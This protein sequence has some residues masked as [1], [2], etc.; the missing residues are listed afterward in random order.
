MSALQKS[1]QCLSREINARERKKMY[2][3]DVQL[4]PPTT[5]PFYTLP[6]KILK[7]KV[8]TARSKVKSRSHHDIASIH[9]LTNVPTKY[10]LPAPYSFRG[11]ART[12]FQRLRSLQ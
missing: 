12:R 10:Q 6:Y 11:I 8:T 9:Q 2:H 7:V 1:R 3:D 5:V 4:Q